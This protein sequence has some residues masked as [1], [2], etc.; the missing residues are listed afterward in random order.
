M[1]SGHAAQAC[2]AVPVRNANGAITGVLGGSVYLESLSLRLKR[3][4]YLQPN[5]IFF[6]VNATPIGALQ[7][8]PEQTF[9]D[10]YDLDEPELERA[11]REIWRG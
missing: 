10:P 8:D 7:D 4:I 3:E 6:S 1:S 5:Q 11:I 9:L 2:N